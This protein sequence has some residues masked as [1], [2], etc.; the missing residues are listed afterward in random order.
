M[1]VWAAALHSPSG[2]SERA[3][4]ASTGPAKYIDRRAKLAL[5]RVARAYAV[6]CEAPS[7]EVRDV[8]LRRVRPRRTELLDHV[9]L[10]YRLQNRFWAR[11]YDFHVI[12]SVARETTAD[13]GAPAT[14]VKL[15]LGGLAGAKS[16]SFVAQLRDEE[17]LAEELSSTPELAHLV[18]ALNLTDIRISTRDAREERDWVIDTSGYVGSYTWNLIPPV[19]QAILPTPDEV[20]QHLQLLAMLAHIVRSPAVR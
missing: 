8:W 17:A 4:V 10:A 7:P 9:D 5:D 19:Y 18:R 3:T 1:T 12:T 13:R 6:A 11:I 2:L 15:K 20:N 16:V 14:H